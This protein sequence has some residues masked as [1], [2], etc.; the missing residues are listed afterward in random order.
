MAVEEEQHSGRCVSGKEWH[1]ECFD[2]T[3]QEK[4]VGSPLSLDDLKGEPLRRAVRGAGALARRMLASGLEPG[5]RVALLADTD[6]DFIRAFF[7]CQYAGMIPAPL[8]LPAPLGGREPYVAQITRMLQ[9]AD[10]AG[11]LRLAADATR[12]W[13]AQE[14]LIP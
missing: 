4:V 6:G 5:E 10:A 13:L 14:R 11:A 12:S 7:A 2:S 3:K 8:P 1:K 9:A